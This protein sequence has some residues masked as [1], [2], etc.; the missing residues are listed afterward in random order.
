MSD[1]YPRDIAE[2][3]LISLGI[4]FEAM[5]NDS[6]GIVR[7]QLQIL[8]QASKHFNA[9][10]LAKDARKTIAR[11]SNT[12]NQ[13]YAANLYNT[14]LGILTTS[15]TE[16]YYR[17]ANPNQMVTWLPSDAEEQDLEHALN[18]GKTMTVKT[19]QKKGLGIRIG[20]KCGF[21][22]KKEDDTITQLNK[23]FSV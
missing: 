5:A 12:P 13:N 10:N 7:A 19:A 4:D 9:P 23:Q 2:E 17:T 11:I 1:L 15:I 16:E 6:G 14:V 18:Y 8:T 3:Y 21:S 22:F 20:C